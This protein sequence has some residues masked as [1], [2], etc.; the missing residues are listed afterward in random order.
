MD[1][2]PTRR[3][4]FAPDDELAARTA[5]LLLT[6][7]PVCILDA[8]RVSLTDRLEF[9]DSVMSLL[10]YGMW[11][12]MSASTW[13]SST[14][15]GHKFRLFFSNAPRQINEQD[16]VVIWGHPE[17]SP[18]RLPMDMRL[19]IRRGWKTGSRRRWH[20]WPG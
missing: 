12:R 17:R 15:Q 7:N 16:H 9:I 2:G 14:Y 6:G 8:D 20:G 18:G 13:T 11:S 1:Q 5:A 4:L 3:A 19:P 10:P